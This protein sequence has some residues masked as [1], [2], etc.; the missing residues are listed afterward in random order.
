[1]SD[2]VELFQKVGSTYKLILPVQFSLEQFYVAKSR[3]YG[4]IVSGAN[5][6]KIN[7][8]WLNFG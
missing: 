5:C 2:R 8:F 7:N 4:K 1:M 6:G 3:S